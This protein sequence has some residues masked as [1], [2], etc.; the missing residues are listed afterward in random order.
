MVHDEL[1]VLSVWEVDMQQLKYWSRKVD[2]VFVEKKG[3]EIRE[4]S[5]LLDE[6]YWTE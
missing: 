1:K 6:E 2:G 4:V 3:V 5:S